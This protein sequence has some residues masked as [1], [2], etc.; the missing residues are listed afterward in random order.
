MM[1]ESED[2]LDDLDA[3]FDG[4]DEDDGDPEYDFMNDN[5][6]LQASLSGMSGILLFQYNCEIFHFF[7]LG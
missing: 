6:S 4:S 3:I 1:M 7:F 2:G 5:P